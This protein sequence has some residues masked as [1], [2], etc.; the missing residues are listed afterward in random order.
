MATPQ[1]QQ[2]IKD[3]VKAKHQNPMMSTQLHLKIAEIHDNTA[4][5]KNG[6]LRAVLKTSSVN[7]HLKSEEEQN[8]VIFS[9][10]HF[11]NSLEFPIQIVIRSKKLD[12]DNY[13]AN[14]KKIEAKQENRLLK[15]QTVEY[16]E[17][18]QKLIE[19]ADIM[20]KEFFVVIPQN[21]YRT[22]QNPNFLK[23]IIEN[24]NSKDTIAKIKQRKTEF[25]QLQ[26]QLNQR[27]NVV[28]SGLENCGL[29]V[30]LLNTQQLIEL[31]YETYNPLTAR[32]QKI[33]NI[34]KINIELDS[35]AKP[36]PNV[37]MA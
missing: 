17:Y 24:F 35:D 34:N 8:A 19:Y 23:T 9:Y 28:K 4:V 27:I 37:A 16:I 21:P 14:L 26:K 32:S 36:N 18:I 10:Q 1:P 11:L 29:H 2:Q 6:G 12:L 7:L 25:D 13:I 15:E 33:A 30:D 31:F 3:T 22:S 5:L 20:E